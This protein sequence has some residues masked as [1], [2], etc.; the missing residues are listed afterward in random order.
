M[1]TGKE[2]LAEEVLR[3]KKA[4]CLAAIWLGHGWQ[5]KSEGWLSM[6]N[7]SEWPRKKVP[8][9]EEDFGRCLQQIVERPVAATTKSA[10]RWMA[11]QFD[12]WQAGGRAV[13]TICTVQEF[14]REFGLMRVRS[15]I[16][17]PPYASLVMQ[18]LHSVAVRH[19][20]YMLAR[21]LELVYGLF[22]DC[23]ALLKPI[24]WSSRPEWAGGASENVQAFV[25][26]LARGHIMEHPDLPV[27]VQK[28]LL[29]QGRSLRQ[30]IISVPETITGEHYV[31]ESHTRSIDRLFGEVKQ[32]RDSFVHCEPGPQPSQRSGRVKEDLFHGISTEL[33]DESVFLTATVIRQLWQFVFKVGGPRWL[34][35][36][37][38][39]SLQRDLHLVPKTTC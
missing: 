36:L 27:E 38:P 39:A 7:Y 12:R 6:E 8:L 13:F 32:A 31:L 9:L 19:P 34:P 37:V 3:L 14:E 26:G 17:V 21:D 1:G 28:K 33:V 15:A 20:E 5:L 16:E 25:S 22:L 18:G 4:W 11:Q 2:R 23:E 24:D 30:R 29:D 35:S 10:V